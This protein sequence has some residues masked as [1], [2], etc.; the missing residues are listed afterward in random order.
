MDKIRKS[1]VS[2]LKQL[3]QKYHN[4]PLGILLDQAVGR[5]K[6]NEISDQR[7]EEL[8]ERFLKTGEPYL[9]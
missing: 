2:L 7:L 3:M 4:M 1:V 8:L 9:G 6:L 5:E